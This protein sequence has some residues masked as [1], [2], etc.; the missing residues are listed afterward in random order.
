MDF[1]LFF[2]MGVG[3]LVSSMNFYISFLTRKKMGSGIPMLGSLFLFIG[4]FFIDNSILF[5]LAVV[6]IVL[7]TGGI[8]WAVA[9]VLYYE[10]IG[11]LTLLR[12][13]AKVL[14]KQTEKALEKNRNNID[15][16]EKATIESALNELKAV[17]E[18]T[19]ATKE[20][21]EVTTKKL[22]DVSHKMVDQMYRDKGVIRLA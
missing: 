22:A 14:S 18:N 15:D 4:L 13:Q 21:L 12:N 3:F 2:F 11:K 1:I 6:F 17:V 8:H 9:T 10:T 20:E 19:D 7:D 5:E 16:T